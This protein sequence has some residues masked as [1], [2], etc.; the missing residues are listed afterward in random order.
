[1][2]SPFSIFYVMLSAAKYPQQS[3]RDSSVA[4]NTPSE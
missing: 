3:N 2:L 4:A 1:M